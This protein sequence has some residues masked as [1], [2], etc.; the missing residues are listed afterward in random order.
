[1]KGGPRALWLLTHNRVRHN[2]Q[3]HAV[4]DFLYERLRQRALLTASLA[5]D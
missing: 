1:V 5:G 4:S 2:A 3:V